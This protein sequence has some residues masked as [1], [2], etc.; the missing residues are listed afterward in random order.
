MTAAAGAVVGAALVAFAPAHHLFV[1]T[2]LH[3]DE[4]AGA[5]PEGARYACPM[6]DFIGTKPGDCPV[7]GMHMRLVE[8]GELSEA[9][10]R[11]IG[12]RTVRAELGPAV[13]TVRAYGTA[14]YD[15]RHT[16]VVLPRVSGRIVKRHEA[17]FGC[18]QTVHEG[19]PIVDLYSPEVIAAQGELKAA[20]ELGS[21]SVIK[22]LHER[23]AR[24][25]LDDVAHA[26]LDGGEVSTFVT[27]R[28]P[29][30]GQ[31]LQEDVEM[32]NTSLEVGREVDP[33]MPLLRLVD[34]DKLVLVLHVPETKSRWLR[35]GQPVALATDDAGPLPQVRA[36]VSRVA[37]ELSAEIRAREVRVDLENARSLISPGSL[38][39]ARLSAGLGADLQAADPEDPSSLASFVLVPKSAVLS[40]GVRDVVWKVVSRGRDGRT[41]FEP[42]AVALGPRLESVDGDDRYIVRAG[43][44]AGDEVATQGAFLIDSQ[45]Q[46]AGTPSL[47][48]PTGA[49]G[50]APA[51]PAE[52]QGGGNHVHA[53]P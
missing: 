25:N 13:V 19:D 40:T 8:T 35:V 42:R 20:K 18:C 46:L 37:A 49:P 9:Q 38:V 28:S 3:G 21:Q 12:L 47:L 36:V 30:S 48:F 41:R 24:W 7:C 45:A 6:M 44:A 10:A 31:V 51:A 17:T 4:P 1:A 33:A 5:A 22:S 2:A 43:L 27:I 26:I 34:P 14:E 53:V 52:V 32:V 16:K 39:S 50:T 23:F 29:Y 11:R 15:H